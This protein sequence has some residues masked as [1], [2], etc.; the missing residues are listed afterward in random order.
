[1]LVARFCSPGLAAWLS[2]VS[3]VVLST[4]AAAAPRAGAGSDSAA[5]AALAERYR[6]ARVRMDPVQFG[7][8][9]GDNRYDDQLQITIAPAHR[10]Q[11]FAN[12]RQFL[13]QLAAIDRNRLDRSDA[14]THELL[15]AEL[16]TQLGFEAFADHLLPL[17]QMGPI[18][19]RLARF[20]NGQSEQALNTVAQYEAYLKRIQRLPAWADQAIA[21]LREGMRRGI[22]Q[23]KPVTEAALAL[24][25]PLGSN[26]LADNAFYA[27]IRN[28]PA[29]FADI[30]RQRLTRSYQAAVQQRIAPAM[31][32]LV[33]FVETRYLPACRDSAGWGALPNG[34]AWYRQWVRDQTTT[35]LD[36]QQIHTMGLKEVARIQE[37]LAKLAPQLGYEGDPR[38]LLAWVRTQAKFLPFR[39]EAEVLAAYR[40]LNDQ[41]EAKLPRLFGRAPKAPLDIRPV[42]E[43]IRASASDHYTPPADDGS[44]PGIFWVVV[45]DPAQYDATAMTA[46]FLHEGRPGHHFQMALQQEMPLPQVRKRAWIN[47]YGEGWALYAESLG[48][49][50]GLYADTAAHVGYLRLEMARAA[51]L[52][53]DTGMHALGWSRDQAVAYW[54]DQVG[55]TEAQAL[56]QIHRYMAWPGQALGYKLG[57][58]KI[59]A[60]RERAQQRLGG[61]FDLARFHDAVLAEGALPLSMLETRIERWIDEQR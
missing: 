16:R 29:T 59:Q 33:R 30:D 22:V 10:R 42:P 31:R 11:R 32:R 1:M 4:G 23:P 43:L 41:L 12:Y 38:Q 57:A 34:A 45:N 18:P 25:G 46:L 28:L 54:I 13:R 5:L 39:S 6:D 37:E 53:V 14:L 50:F 3:C 47:A 8:E 19:L 7:T 40:T 58:L 17:H 26:S 56:N 61:R 15:V 21:N 9:A 2:I 49:E 60:L 48:F 55:A 44:R 52:V 24:L 51:R 35:E 27:P 20:G 36:A